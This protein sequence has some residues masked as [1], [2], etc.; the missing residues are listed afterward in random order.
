MISDRIR[1]YEA[2]DKIISRMVT[3]ARENAPQRAVNRKSA[4]Y[5]AGY[6]N[7]LVIA[8]CMM[9]LGQFPNVPENKDTI[10]KALK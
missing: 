5:R 1:G 9:V 4:A 7:G 8:H 2:A 3:N 10:D 6:F